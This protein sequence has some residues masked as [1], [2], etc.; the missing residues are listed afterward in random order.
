ME[1]SEEV[2]KARLLYHLRSKRVIGG[3]HTH[4]DTL[5]RGFP[6]HLG[7]EVK[8]VAHELIK[9]GW[10]ITKPTSYGLQVSLNKERILEIDTF[11]SRVLGFKL[12]I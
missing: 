8:K 3:K 5:N 7:K 9:S 2:I 10:L 6:S 12:S 1:F 4:F 11:I